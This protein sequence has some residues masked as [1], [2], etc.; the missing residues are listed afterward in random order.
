MSATRIRAALLL[1]FCLATS[2]LAG[3]AQLV[4]TGIGGVL[5][6]KAAGHESTTPRPSR[7]PPDEMRQAPKR[8]RNAPAGV[9]A[10]PAKSATGKARTAP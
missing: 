6:D 5:P 8:N 2:G 3:A 10:A 1:G 9:V 4:G 7:R